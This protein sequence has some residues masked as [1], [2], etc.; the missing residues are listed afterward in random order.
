MAGIS[1][2]TA[3]PGTS[4]ARYASGSIVREPYLERARRISKL[5]I[6]SLFRDQ[7]E[8]GTSSVVIAW[9]S[10]G[11][12]LV[13]NL[14]SKRVM[15][16][17]PPGI[18]PIQLKPGRQALEDLDALE[19]DV[20]G[21]LRQGIDKGLSRIEVE[22][23]EGCEEDGDRAKHF[24]AQRHLAVGGNHCLHLRADDRLASIAL[25]RYVTWRDPSGT[26]IEWIIEDALSWDTLPEDVKAMAPDRKAREEDDNSRD[27]PILVYTHGRLRGGQ[28]RVHQEA[29]GKRVPGTEW[30][31]DVEACPYMFLVENLIK[32][33]HYARSYCEDYEAD[34]QSLDAIWQILIEGGA[35]AALLKWLIKAGGTTNKKAFS[36]AANGAVITGDPDD[37]AAV[38]ADKGGDLQIAFKLA[39]AAEAR[40]EKVF[41][42][43]SQRSGERVTA[44]EIRR[45]SQELETTQGGSYSN[46]VVTYQAPY[47]RVKLQALMKHG[48]V[49]K[50]PKGSF[51]I[52]ILTGDAALGRLQKSQTLRE[53]IQ[54]GSAL[55]PQ[56]FPQYINVRS[57][58][59]RDGANVSLDTEGLVRSEEAMA[60]EAAQAQG[61]LLSEKVAPEVVRQGGE[62]LQNQLQQDQAGIELPVGQ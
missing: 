31:W 34:L 23:V 51:R 58:I 21:E 37:V 24:D 11:A 16:L 5:T 36:E 30:S 52:T 8:D 61:Q 7:G 33:E 35:A 29:F 43:F 27:A 59:D 49:R 48:R 22:F 57:Y 47:A 26:V 40:L 3:S 54:V 62:I 38:R 60:A 9:Q 14:V 15:A 4:A 50:L 41:L 18:A 56:Q 32:G 55:F 39:E 20:R 19:E 6:P 53:F 1:A 25:E 10:G 12:R 2:A 28:Y 13:N 17:F 46:Q 44:E 42:V 45:I